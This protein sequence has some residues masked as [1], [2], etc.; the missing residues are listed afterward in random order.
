[1][2]MRHTFEIDGI[3]INPELPEEFDVTPHE[4]R[5]EEMN[6]WWDKPYIEIVELSQ[7]SWIE[8]FYRLKDDFISEELGTEEEYKKRLEKDKISWFETWHTG[9]RYCVRC[10]DG[11]AWDRSTNHG[12]YATFEEALQVAKNIKGEE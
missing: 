12:M 10:L 8:H 6:Y 11:G 9:F 2:S 5:D 1:M 3:Y 7:E 4:E